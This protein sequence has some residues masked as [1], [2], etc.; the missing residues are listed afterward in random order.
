MKKKKAVSYYRPLKAA[1]Q[2]KTSKLASM[3]SRRPRFYMSFIT[4][5]LGNL[6]QFSL[7]A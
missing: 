3:Y 1:V 5:L 7:F 2:A 6:E 4:S